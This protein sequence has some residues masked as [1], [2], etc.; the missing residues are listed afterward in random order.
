MTAQELETNQNIESIAQSVV[1]DANHYVESIAAL[2][3]T[4]ELHAVADIVSSSGMMLVARGTKIDKKVHNKLFSHRL[5]G[6]T[7]EKSLSVTGSVTTDSLVADISRLIEKDPWVKQLATKSGDAGALRHGIS[8]VALPTEILFRLTIAREQR[9]EL[10]LHSLT[11]TV[12]AHYLAL[13]LELSQKLIDNVLIA[14]LCHDL[15]EL[16]TDPTILHTEHKISKAERRFIHVHP[17]T[18]WLILRD[19]ES[20]DQEIARMVI[21]HHERLDGSGYPHGIKGE[22][23]SI[24]ARI[25]AAAEI[26]AGIMARFQDPRRLATLLRLNRRKYDHKI[27]D[28]LLETVASSPLGSGQ[29]D[30]EAS[31]KYLANFAQLMKGWSS[32]LTCMGSTATE[33][34]AFLAQRLSSI[35]SVIV[36]S[37]FDPDGIDTLFQLASED[38]TISMEITTVIDE[39]KYQLAELENEIDR[40]EHSWTNI[41]DPVTSVALS[42]WR[43]QL[44]ELLAT[45][46]T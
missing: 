26:S 11:V 6:R 15:G 12:I 8:R 23:I 4:H 24:T 38:S 32:L 30:A 13:R 36:S 40:H 21:Q 17:I 19:I 35:R 37:G 18:G 22:T 28:L 27:V 39:L 34:I 41:V 44:H 20:L 25:L 16:Y 14:A 5:S 42:D 3:G 9:P 33:S 29:Y 46:S 10:Y 1:A 45:S 43:Q 2:A 31:K 7:L